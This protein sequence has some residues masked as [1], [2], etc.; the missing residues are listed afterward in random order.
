MAPSQTNR[1][2]VVEAGIQEIR[3]FMQG[4]EEQLR[5][6][7]TIHENSLWKSQSEND[8]KFDEL[9]AALSTHQ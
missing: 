6:V 8:A 2:E 5:N 9:R 7:S 1:L 3:L 4:L